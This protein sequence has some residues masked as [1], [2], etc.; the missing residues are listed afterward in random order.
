MVM[1]YGIGGIG[2]TTMAPNGL[3]M[4]AVM[5]SREELAL[6]KISNEEWQM[7]LQTARFTIPHWKATNPFQRNYAQFMDNIDQPQVFAKYLKP[8]HSYL[9]KLLYNIQPVMR[10]LKYL[11]KA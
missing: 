9:A 2:M 3:L 7:N 6:G 5:N 4:K 8:K 11:I 1:L 10:S